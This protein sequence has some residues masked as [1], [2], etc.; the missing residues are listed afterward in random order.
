[1]IV[2]LN[3]GQTVKIKS[4]YYSII[5]NSLIIYKSHFKFE[6]EVLAIFKMDNIA[7]FRMKKY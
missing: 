5:D 2:Y 6:D 1:M 7:G 4:E 3:N